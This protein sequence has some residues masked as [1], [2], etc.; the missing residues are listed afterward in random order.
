MAANTKYKEF[1]LEDPNK[2]KK[3]KNSKKL[4][5]PKIRSRTPSQ[6]GFRNAI[7]K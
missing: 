6:A 5:L 2:Y 1:W 4:K 3:S 7:I